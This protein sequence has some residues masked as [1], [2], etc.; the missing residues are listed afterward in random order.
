MGVP[1]DMWTAPRE[2]ALRGVQLDQLVVARDHGPSLSLIH[3]PGP[4]RGQQVPLGP[5]GKTGS[6]A[7]PLIQMWVELPNTSKNITDVQV[8]T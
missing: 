4:G 3:G 6:T 8:A 7:E 1:K 5:R 2:Y